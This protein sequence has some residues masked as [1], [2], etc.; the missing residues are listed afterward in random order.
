[1]DDVRI[2]VLGMLL[3]PFIPAL[4]LAVVRNARRFFVTRALGA[5]G[6]SIDQQLDAK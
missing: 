1:M 4:I 2:W 6:K 3:V 5:R